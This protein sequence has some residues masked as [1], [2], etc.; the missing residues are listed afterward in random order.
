M[1]N[2][3]LLAAAAA[4]ALPATPA[5][6]LAALGP[7]PPPCIVLAASSPGCAAPVAEY[8]GWYLRG[9]IGM[10]NQSVSSLNNVVSPG[11]SVSTPFL[12]FDSAPIFDLGVGYQLNNGRRFDLTGEYRA[13]APF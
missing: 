13:H 6:H 5:P 11:T 4:A 1:R 7:P 8:S 2:T 9:D 3:R 10:S 12:T